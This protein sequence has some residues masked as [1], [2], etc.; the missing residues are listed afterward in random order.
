MHLTVKKNGLIIKQTLINIF[1]SALNNM[2]LTE[3]QS[4]KTS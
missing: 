4:N 2:F 1:I 3:Y